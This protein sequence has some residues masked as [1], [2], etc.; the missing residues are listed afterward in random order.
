M[1]KKVFK[2]H[3]DTQPAG[4]KSWLEC[5]SP[6]NCNGT[7]QFEIN[8]FKCNKCGDIMQ[9]IVADE[10]RTINFGGVTSYN[11]SPS[12][13]VHL[14]PGDKLMMYREDKNGTQSDD[15]IV[16]EFDTTTLSGK[17]IEMITVETI[18]NIIVTLK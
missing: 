14:K 1:A 5:N 18:Y 4:T 11:N 12:Y 9:A 10:G 13:H 3:P 15:I 17:E 7:Y 2:Y 16:K 8:K 6:T